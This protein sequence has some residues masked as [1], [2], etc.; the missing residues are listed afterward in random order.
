MRKVQSSG[1]RASITIVHIKN[2]FKMETNIVQLRFIFRTAKRSIIDHPFNPLK[3]VQRP[4][5]FAIVCI[6][7]CEF[8]TVQSVILKAVQ[9]KSLTSRKAQKLL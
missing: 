4:A 1:F 8:C 7:F 2:F 5:A 9:S 3:G 6:C